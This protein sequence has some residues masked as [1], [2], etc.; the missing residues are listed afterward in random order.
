MIAPGDATTRGVA[1]SRRSAGRWTWLV[2][3]AVLAIALFIGSRGDGEPR[4]ERQRINAIASEVRC[5]T[6]RGLSAAESD[7]KAAEAVRTEIARR[8]EDGQTD[9]EIKAYLASRYGSDILL[10]PE[11][12]GVSALVWALPVGA[13]VVASAGLVFA[14]RRWRPTSPTPATDADVVLVARARAGARR[15]EPE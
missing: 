12:S 4:T 7:A 15:D 2:M 1:T 8:V 6:C 11:G 13:L 14:F 10:R 3:V 9:G 5:P